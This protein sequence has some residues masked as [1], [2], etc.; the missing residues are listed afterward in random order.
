MLLVDACA[1]PS[2][3]A[4]E[5]RRDPV[6]LQASHFYVVNRREHTRAWGY[7]EEPPSP[8]FDDFRRGSGDIAQVLL[9][10]NPPVHIAGA[11]GS[12]YASV[13][14]LLIATH[15]DG[16]LH[17]YVGCYQAHAVNPGMLPTPDA[18]WS[19][20]AATVMPAPGNSSDALLLDGVCPIR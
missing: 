13:P 12:L 7:W 9:A 8:S 19:L 16:S 20:W 10:V 6:A 14:A 11:G 3:G 17:G 4:Y 15:T 18:E 1:V 2:R 5:D